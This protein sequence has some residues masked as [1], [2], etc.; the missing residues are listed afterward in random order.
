MRG[1][2]D[3]PVRAYRVRDHRLYVTPDDHARLVQLARSGGVTVSQILRAA[4]NDYLEGVG[5]PLLAE[6]TFERAPNQADPPVASVD[7]TTAEQNRLI[8]AEIR[9]VRRA[10]RENQTP[11]EKAA[12]QVAAWQVE[13]SQYVREQAS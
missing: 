3:A 4:V 12:K 11:D 10:Q 9:R 2:G 5:E 7:A 13:R 8:W 6:M 1:E